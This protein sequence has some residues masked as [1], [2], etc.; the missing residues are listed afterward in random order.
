MFAVLQYRATYMYTTY[1]HTTYIYTHMFASGVSCDIL[2]IPPPHMVY[3]YMAFMTIY[4]TY[5]YMLWLR[6][7]GSFKL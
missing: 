5:I 4:A 1:I 7:V 3:I 6:L 2:Y